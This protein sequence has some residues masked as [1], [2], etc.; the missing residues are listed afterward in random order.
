M[1]EANAVTPISHRRRHAPFY[2]AAL[3]AAAAVPV[4]LLVV[5]GVVLTIEVAAN[6][7]FL[8]YLGL[9]AKK[10]RGLSAA[11]LR[12][13]A[14]TADDPVWAIFAVTLGA[15]VTAVVSLF[16]VINGKHD[17]LT[18]ALSL[19]SV[20]LGW[21]TIHTMASLH[22]AHRYWQRP[23]PGAVREQGGLQFPGTDEP[24]GYDFLYF[25]FVIGM[26]AQTSDVDIT[27][28][29]MRRINLAHAVVSFLFN[30][31]LVAAAVNVA[32]SL[33]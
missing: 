18:V 21:L 20:A 23:G 31:V 33:T 24:E 17:T 8:V 4:A 15:V 25:G 16:V 9:C 27:S 29:L 13:H 10:I 32:L 6:T 1:N 3:C 26:T 28:S 7:F 12:A 2:I 22:Y 5:S 30:T 19:A 11:V 14:A